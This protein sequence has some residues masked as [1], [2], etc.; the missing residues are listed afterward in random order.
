MSTRDISTEIPILNEIMSDAKVTA[1]Q[2]AYAGDDMTDLIVMRQVGL[3]V[4]V[5]NARPEVKHA[6]HYVT[7]RPGGS[8]A[9]REVIE[10]ILQAQDLWSG[11]LERYQA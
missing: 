10:I 9:I 3:A 7:G 11:I 8:G 5:A 6:A 1:E 2:V 4:A